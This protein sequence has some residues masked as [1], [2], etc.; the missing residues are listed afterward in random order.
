MKKLIRLDAAKTLAPAR[1][2]AALAALALSA[3]P[4]APALAQGQPAAG[5]QDKT[6]SRSK[7]ERKMRAPVS[8]DVLRVKLPKAVEAKLDNGLTVLVL[9]DHRFPVVTM[10][11]GISGAGPLYEPADTP[12]LATVTAQMLREGT[13]TRTSRQLSE[14]IERLGAS[15]GASSGFGSSSANVNASGLS[16]NFDQWFALFTDILLNPTFPADE[17][18]RMKTRTK[19][20]LRLQRTQPFFLANE[21]FSAAVYGKHPAGVVSTTPEVLDKLTP[22]LL[23]RWHAERYAPQNSILGIAGDVRAADVIAKLKQAFAGWKKTDAKEV[24][25][26]HP[27]PAASKKIFL[28]D[29]PDSVQSTIVMG[30]IAIDRRS[31]DYVPLVVMDSIVGGGASARLF[32]NL[33][34]DK[35]YTYGVYSGFTALKYPGPWSAS[36]DVRTEVTEG[37]VNELL[38][39]MRRIRDESVPAA[40]L[41]EKKRAIVAG[42]A[43]SLESPASLLNY[44]MLRKIYDLPADYWDTYPA[45]IMAV[46]AEDVQRVARRYVNPET[47][48]VVVVGDASKIRAI[49]E[50]FGPVEVYNTEGKPLAEAMKS[51]TP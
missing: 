18:T 15:L 47:H 41:E 16:D 2:L 4:L 30:N 34:E 28:I 31:P 32:L 22:E 38:Y 11:L 42:F 20:Q 3:A 5:G 6:V 10:R 17:L 45:R 23:A 46:T 35:G 19:T 33:R 50:K 51:T 24:L 7:V 36:G 37:A 49:L 40:E 9:E 26:P 12:G 29:R 44:E 14:E 8:K 27:A 39:E 25:P 13:K 21:R 1:S 48:Q 43:L